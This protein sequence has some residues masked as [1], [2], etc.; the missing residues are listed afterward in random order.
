MPKEL[1]NNTEFRFKFDKALSDY[2]SAIESD[3]EPPVAAKIFLKA[4]FGADADAA[5]A[6][7]SI[8]EQ[9]NDERTARTLQDIVVNAYSG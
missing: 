2:N 1:F 9:L 3:E 7:A 5:F 4:T 6:Y 8:L